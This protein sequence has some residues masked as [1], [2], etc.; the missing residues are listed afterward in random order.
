MV[1][2]ASAILKFCMHFGLAFGIIEPFT[3]NLTIK[4]CCGGAKSPEHAF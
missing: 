2:A 1:M 3:N 4:G